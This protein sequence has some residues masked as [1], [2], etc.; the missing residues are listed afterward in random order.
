MSFEGNIP[1][2]RCPHCP[3]GQQWHPATAEFFDSSKQTTDG[4]H[5]WCKA[6]KSAYYKARC[7]LPEI[8][9]QVRTQQ[10][11]R[12]SR[13][14]FRVRHLAHLK[15]YRQRKKEA[16]PH[17]S[18]RTREAIHAYQKIY[19]SRP[20]IQERNRIKAA[21]RRARKKAATGTYTAQDVQAQYK[22]QK[23]KCYWCGKKLGKYDV[24]HIVP[25]SRGGSNQ[26]DNL[27]I[28]CPTCNQKRNNKLPHEFYE[29]GRLL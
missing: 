2:K 11:I 29:G 10:Q 6:C 15:A 7:T 26:P 13:P 3:E 17:R 12:R 24:D 4:L 1:L 8:V 27:V 5:S 9:E 20:E 14:D 23:G 19:R 16:R 21:N 28:A 25:L 22:R 18:R